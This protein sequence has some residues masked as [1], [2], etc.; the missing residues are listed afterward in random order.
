MS[1]ATGKDADDLPTDTEETIGDLTFSNSEYESEWEEE[2]EPEYV[3]YN[4]SDFIS[5]PFLSE[6]ST[7]PENILD[8]QYPFYCLIIL[9]ILY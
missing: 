3:T 4:S 1:D 6:S 2:S 8:F 7:L 5:K 9:F